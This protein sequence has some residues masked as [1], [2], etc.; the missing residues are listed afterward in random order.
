MEIKKFKPANVLSF[1]DAQVEK[2]P[3]R[4]SLVLKRFVYFIFGIAVIYAM[5]WGYKKGFSTAKQEG[6]ELAKDTKTLFLE[7]I[8][9]EYNRKRKNVRMPDPSVHMGGED[10]YKT[11][12][13]YESHSRNSEL[14]QTILDSRKDQIE[15]DSPIREMKNSSGLPSLSDMNRDS[16]DSS[17]PAKGSKT[18]EDFYSKA[19]RHENPSKE[20]ERKSKDNY[21]PNSDTGLLKNET[22]EKTEKTG[23]LIKSGKRKGAQILQNE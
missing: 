2:I 23:R 14:G 12:K 9:R 20:L 22:P 18:E 16:F 15:R 13:R 17:E 5:Y 6:Q 10:L 1:L 4:I 8:E 7:E 11:E 3:E 19:L 21:V